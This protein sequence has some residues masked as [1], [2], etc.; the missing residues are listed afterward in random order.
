MPKDTIDPKRE[1][2]NNDDEWEESFQGINRFLH[3]ILNEYCPA[4]QA[5]VSEQE[6]MPSEKRDKNAKKNMR[7]YDHQ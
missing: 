7:D 1:I 3:S 5:W 6:Y 4:I 2:P